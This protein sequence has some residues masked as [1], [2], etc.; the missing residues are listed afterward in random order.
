MISLKNKPSKT[1]SRTD[2]D[3]KEN[4]A[5]NMNKAKH[6]PERVFGRDITKAQANSKYDFMLVKEANSINLPSFL[7]AQ[8]QTDR[9][10]QPYE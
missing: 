4:I 7:C 8:H 10:L 6:D 9:A 1:N 3:G 5:K 2:L